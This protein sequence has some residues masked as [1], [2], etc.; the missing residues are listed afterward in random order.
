MELESP[1]RYFLS[2]LH[3]ILSS[4]FISIEIS[5]NIKLSRNLFFMLLNQ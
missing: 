4:I 1:I 3:L 2:N 5:K